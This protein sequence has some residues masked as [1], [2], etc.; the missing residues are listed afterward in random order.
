MPVN[1]YNVY[2]I[3]KNE[4]IFRERAK[5]IND[6]YKGKI[7]HIQFVPAEYLT[8]TQCN[9][10]MLKKLK[11]LHN[12]K[13]KSIIAKL[14]CIA[15]HRKALLA[16]YSNQT[17]N[18]LILE[19]DAGLMSGL[20]LP[21]GKSCYMGGWIIP[22]KVTLAG[23]VKVDIKPHRGLNKI[24]YDTFKIIT[25]HALFIKDHEE[26][27]DLLDMTIEPESL[28][29]YD[30]FLAQE[31]FFKDFYYPSVFVQEKHKSEIDDKGADLNYYR[32]YNYGLEKPKEKKEKGKLKRTK[33]KG[34]DNK[35]K[36]LL[37]K[38]GASIKTYKNGRQDLIFTKKKE[39]EYDKLIKKDF[40]KGLKVLL[41]LKKAC[42]IDKKEK[43]GGGTRRISYNT[44][45]SI[46]DCNDTCTKT[47]KKDKKMLEIHKRK[48]FNKKDVKYLVKWGNK[49]KKC[50]KK[51]LKRT[52][53]KIT[54]T[55]SKKTPGHVSYSGIGSVEEDHY[56]YSPEEFL[57]IMHKNFPEVKKQNK[58]DVDKWIT[59]SGAC[60]VYC[61]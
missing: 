44:N 49:T 37:K 54:I 50:N 20:P 55:K 26:A 13:K 10:K 11:T 56:M 42:S 43:K 34:G 1:K 59:W 32:T 46:N 29:P 60:K 38:H 14:G 21:P 3:C 5:K 45:K 35:C 22:P 28:K 58:N 30:I 6:K 40:K 48:E 24:N 61:D 52:Q 47:S 27:T 31:K 41:D 12:T 8:L 53:K 7:C 4:E 25:T 18:N 16:I 17:H 36:S 33:K 57:S 15:A 23:K 39:K 19:E 51:C 2:I 9:Q